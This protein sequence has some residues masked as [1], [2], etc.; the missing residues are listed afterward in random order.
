MQNKMVT[1]A[2]RFCD[3]IVDQEIGLNDV[4]VSINEIY[5]KSKERGVRLFVRRSSWIVGL[6]LSLTIY[7]CLCPEDGNHSETFLTFMLLFGLVWN[8][9]HEAKSQEINEVWQMIT[10]EILLEVFLI[11]VSSNIVLISCLFLNE[12]WI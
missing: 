4:V 9:F 6:G 10:P 3:V 2:E 8:S 12:E 11:S 5:S 7:R 1:A